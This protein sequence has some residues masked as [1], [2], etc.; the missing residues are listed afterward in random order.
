MRF[1]MMDHYLEEFGFL[2]LLFEVFFS[3]VGISMRFDVEKDLCGCV[4]DSD[5]GVGIL[6]F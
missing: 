5:F 4:S 1:S 6:M 3:S 2:L